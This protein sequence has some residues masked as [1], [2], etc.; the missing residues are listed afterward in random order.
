MKK[1]QIIDS[2]RR[3][4]DMLDMMLRDTDDDLILANE[5]AESW[6][7]FDVVGH[8]IHGEKNGLDT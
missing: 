3:T 4:P 6:S 1:F 5:G 2:L 8:L 7:P